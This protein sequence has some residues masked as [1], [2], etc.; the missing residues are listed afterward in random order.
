MTNKKQLQQTERGFRV[1]E[2]RFEKRAELLEDE[3]YLKKQELIRSTGIT[4]IP[5]NIIVVIE[6]YL[7]SRLVGICGLYKARI[8]LP[9][10]FIAVDENF[11]GLGIAQSLLRQL[12]EPTRYPVFLRVSHDNIPAYHIYKKLGFLKCPFIRQGIVMVRFP[13][14]MRRPK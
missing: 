4:K 11:R 13:N 6:A 9:A 1:E 2:L 8:I 10:L 3:N 5:K 12:L 7:N 14:L